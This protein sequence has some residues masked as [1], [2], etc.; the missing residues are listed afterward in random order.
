MAPYPTASL[1]RPPLVSSI[2]LLS[3]LVTAC[4][5]YGSALRVRLMILLA[6]AVIVRRA[7]HCSLRGVVLWL[8]SLAGP[9]A[10]RGGRSERAILGGNSLGF[11][12]LEF[13]FTDAVDRV[14]GEGCIKRAGLGEGGRQST[15]FQ[16][17]EQRAMAV[18]CDVVLKVAERRFNAHKCIL[19][20]ASGPLRAMF[21]SGFREG[22]QRVIELRD[23][24]ED[25]FS[26]MLDFIYDEPVD[27]TT[28]NVESLLDLSTR[29]AINRLR[30]HCCVFLSKT[31]EP[32]IACSLLS[33]AHRYDCH[34][35]KAELLSYVLANFGLV[36]EGGREGFLQLSLDLLCEVLSSS[37]LVAPETDVFLA[38]T[39]WLEQDESRLRHRDAVLKL[40]RY[41]RISAEF[42]A[43]IVE[44]HP[45]MSGPTGCQLIH[46][47]YRYLAIAP[48]KRLELGLFAQPR[49]KCVG[50]CLAAGVWP[51][52]ASL[53]VKEKKMPECRS[54]TASDD[55]MDEA[56]VHGVESARREVA[57]GA[58]AAL[59]HQAYV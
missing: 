58:G 17:R 32:A 54:S 7:K 47:A 33:I 10:T 14:E 20:A 8:R 19:C 53:P 5:N 24:P 15:F 21:D 31:V 40:V 35:L 18:S 2:G 39:A 41:Q 28:Y 59:K 50:G 9:I 29:F 42:L 12:P 27:I 52:P 49:I 25:T 51:A 6:A 56:P 4:G 37:D 22:S 36:C 16:L 11:N 43:E 44:V 46:E 45:L 3:E 38:A 30:E 26:L 23:V 13:C 55:A 1:T 57:A 48:Q 34:S